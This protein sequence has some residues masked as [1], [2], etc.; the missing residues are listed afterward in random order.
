MQPSLIVG[1]LTVALLLALAL[2]LWLGLRAR[3]G[4]GR[5]VRRAPALKYPVVLAHGVLGFDAIQFAGAKREYFRGVPRRLRQR[6]AEVHLARVHPVASIARRAEEL[7]KT[8]RSLDAKRVNIIAHS[9]GGLDARY[10]IA[11]L[12]LGERVASLTTV[13]TPHRG[14]P[15]ADL[16]TN[17]LGDKLKLKAVFDRLGLGTEA[18]YDLTTERMRGFN[19]EVGDVRGVAYA[20][21]EAVVKKGLMQV[22]ALLLPTVLFLNDQAG[23][24]DGLVPL[25]SQRWGELLGRIEADHWAQIGWSRRFDAPGFYAGVIEELR[26]RGF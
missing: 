15:L 9:M 22:N 2:G 26:G 23:E 13:G 17:L 8:V 5:R 4:L 3:R 10:A 1:G 7:A 11:R 21:Y 14:T 19:E 16:G 20:S 6:G 25:S 12:G 24:N 18:F